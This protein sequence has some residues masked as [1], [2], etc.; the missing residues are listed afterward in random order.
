MSLKDVLQGIELARLFMGAFDRKP[1]ERTGIHLSDSIR[2]NAKC[3]W[4]GADMETSITKT[5][6]IIEGLKLLNTYPKCE[7]AAEHDVFYAGIGL[8]L[9]PEHVVEMERL[10]WHRNTEY[11]CWAIFV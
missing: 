9:T 11:G 5:E 3:K 1:C 6:K 10:G 7:V 4:C 8:E 2:S